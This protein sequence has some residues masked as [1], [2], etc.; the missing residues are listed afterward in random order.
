MSTEIKALIAELREKFATNERELALLNDRSVA[1]AKL[2]AGMSDAS[3]GHDIV[4]IGSLMSKTNF[5]VTD[6]QR[7][8]ASILRSIDVLERHS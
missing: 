1:L 2:R 8:N 5:R 6:L 4:E 3:S 7:E